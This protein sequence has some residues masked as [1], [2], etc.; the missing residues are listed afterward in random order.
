MLEFDYLSVLDEV[1][2][3]QSRYYALM[4]RQIVGQYAQYVP[5]SLECWYPKTAQ[6]AFSAKQQHLLWP[7]LKSCKEKGEQRTNDTTAVRQRPRASLLRFNKGSVI[8]T[9]R[10]FPLLILFY[11]CKSGFCAEKN[12]VT[13]DLYTHPQ[14]YRQ[15]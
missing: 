12:M 11:I 1:K 14:S 10:F 5:A 8:A 3:S 4:N 6:I 7:F 2:V 9:Y 15:Q 13:W